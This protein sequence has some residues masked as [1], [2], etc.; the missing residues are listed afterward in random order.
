MYVGLAWYLDDPTDKSLR[1]TAIT[2]ATTN[3][4]N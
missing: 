4:S 3:R 2:F 1:K